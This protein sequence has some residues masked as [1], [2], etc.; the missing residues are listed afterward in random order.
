MNNEVEKHYAACKDETTVVDKFIRALIKDAQSPEPALHW[1]YVPGETEN[2]PDKFAVNGFSGSD[3]QIILSMTDITDEHDSYK[4]VYYR[5]GE[6]ILS[7][8]EYALLTE[9]SD[10]RQLH[11]IV[12]HGKDCPR[13]ELEKYEDIRKFI[14][15]TDERIFLD[16]ILGR[17]F[18]TTTPILV[19]DVFRGANATKVAEMYMK[20]VIQTD[21]TH[22]DEEELRRIRALAT[23]IISAIR[24]T[25]REPNGATFS[26]RPVSAVVVTNKPVRTTSSLSSLSQIANSMTTWHEIYVDSPETH[27]ENINRT[28]VMLLTAIMQEK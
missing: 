3:A 16:R 18:P 21:E 27:K 22:S 1:E 7:A 13:D 25:K 6:E 8:Q 4:L 20:T 15:D 23:A 14:T 9:Q 24:H 17:D 19:G 12:S 2:E 28:A 5:K 26:P 11:S 10:L